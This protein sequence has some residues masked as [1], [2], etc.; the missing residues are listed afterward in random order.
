ML[1]LSLE[2]ESNAKSDAKVGFLNFDIIHKIASP[3]QGTSHR[4]LFFLQTQS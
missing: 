2:V 1:K 4:I 3:N